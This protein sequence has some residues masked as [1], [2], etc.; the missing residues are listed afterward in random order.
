MFRLF[1]QIASAIII[2]FVFLVA[3][4][5]SMYLNIKFQIPKIICILIFVF[6]VFIVAKGLDLM[7]SRRDENETL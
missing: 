7:F 5:F 1:E 2:L 3:A 4:M 6:L